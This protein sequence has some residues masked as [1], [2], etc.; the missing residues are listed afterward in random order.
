MKRLKLETDFSDF[1]K[2]CKKYEVEYLVIGG[3]AGAYMV[4]PVLQKILMFASKSQKRTHRK[5]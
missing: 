1:V 4:I 2:L 3:Y 5:W